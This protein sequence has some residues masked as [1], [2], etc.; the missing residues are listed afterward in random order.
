MNAN[1]LWH[2]NTKPSGRLGSGDARSDS[3]TRTHH[4]ELEPELQPV[5]Y[6]AVA[7][8]GRRIADAALE[9]RIRLAFLAFEF[10]PA[11]IASKHCADS[12]TGAAAHRFCGWSL[13]GGCG[14]PDTMFREGALDSEHYWAGTNQDEIDDATE[15]LR[16]AA[17]DDG[18][19]REMN[20]NAPRRPRWSLG[21]PPSRASNTF[22][23]VCCSITAPGIPSRHRLESDFYQAAHREIFKHVAQLIQCGA[24]ADPVTM[25]T[26]SSVSGNWN[27]SGTARTSRCSQRARSA[28]SG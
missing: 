3:T 14:M 12:S 28:S 20:N 22:S 19:K 6:T 5:C 13:R 23:A 9:L 27:S 16:L 11:R 25:P 15:A 18:Y 8:I 1:Q 7:S 21:S 24:R 4:N 17:L 26:A 10:E 2:Q